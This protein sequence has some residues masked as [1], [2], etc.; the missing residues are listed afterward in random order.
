MT[1]RERVR[2]LIQGGLPDR[3]PF[4]DLLR[5]DAVIEY[6]GGEKLTSENAERVVFHAADSVLDATRPRIALPWREG[7]EVLPDGRKLTRRRWTEWIEPKRFASTD[8]YAEELRARTGQSWDWTETDEDALQKSLQEQR[9]WR[10]MMGDVFLFGRINEVRI[11]GIFNEVGLEEFS[12]LLADDPGAVEECLE[13]QT[14]KALQFIDRV[15]A[16]EPLEAV[17]L[18]SDIAFKN[19]LIFP[20]SLL[21]QI[22]FPRLGMVISACHKRGWKVAYHSDGNLMEVLDDLME[23]GIDMLNPIERLAGMEPK[24]VHE[25]YPDL[26]LLGGIDVSQLL[27]YGSPDEVRSEVIKVI[28]D[29]EG[30]VMVGSTTELHNEVPLRNVIALVETLCSYRY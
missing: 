29:T 22:F 1:S 21:R 5:N 16:D 11:D 28:E 4:F 17:F 18:A 6:Y 24:V 27:P 3:A 23:S 26:V 14:V 9:R 10:E 8:A 13:Y 12:Y 19:R 2:I 25:R 20:P 15:P 7:V 30:K